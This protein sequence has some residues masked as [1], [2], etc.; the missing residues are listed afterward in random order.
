MGKCVAYAVV[1]ALILVGAYVL[2]GEDEYD[3]IGR[4]DRFVA[5]SDGEVVQVAPT[6]AAAPTV[7]VRAVADT[8]Q[9]SAAVADPAATLA[10]SPTAMP[11]S[12][13][14]A[15]PVPRP[16]ATPTPVLPTRT[17]VPTPLPRSSS[18][19]AFVF[20]PSYSAGTNDV[21]VQLM[22]EDMLVLI[23]QVRSRAGVGP[24][25]LGSNRSPQSHAEYMRDGCL[26]SHT[27]SGGSN[28]RQRWERNG[29]SASVRIAENVNGY[30]TCTF[31]V[32]R[33]RSLGYYVTK[34]MD[35]LMN[36]SGHRAIIEDGAYDEVHIGWAISRNG[37]WVTQLF[38]D[39]R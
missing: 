24:V 30:R 11:A 8:G 25:T 17:P 27:G 33:S 19:V 5:Q 1:L 4:L 26:V 23:N 32:P 36:S 12:T 18:Q 7:A 6:S 39:T 21:A 34:L 10:P 29:G 31:T 2:W 38:V 16:T 28:K 37:A 14:T 22:R 9:E 35:S 15:T 3:L 13:P 20:N